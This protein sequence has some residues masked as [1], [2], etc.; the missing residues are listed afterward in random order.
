MSGESI[1]LTGRQ[2]EVLHFTGSEVAADPFRVAHE[3][4][5]LFDCFSGQ[6]YDPA[7]PLDIPQ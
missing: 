1:T 3:V 6:P 2:K 5:S 7:D 4:L